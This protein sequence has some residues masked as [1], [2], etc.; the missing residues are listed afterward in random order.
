MSAFAT[1]IMSIAITAIVIVIAWI[2][3]WWLY[4]RATK[5]ISFVRTGFGGQKIIINGGSLV[6]PVLHDV[7]NVDMSTVRLEISRSEKDSIITR[8]RMRVDMTV[9]FYVRVKS[10]KEAIA[11]AAQTIGSRA[12]RSEPMREILEGRFID[13]LRTVTAEMSMEE[14]HEQRG[15]FISRVKQL[16]RNEIDQIGL[17]LE[18]ASLTVFDQTERTFFNPHN[19]F[20]AEGLTRLIDEIEARRM[21]RNEIEQ[22]SEVRI[23]QRNLEAET[24]KLAISREEEFIRL[25]Q[26]K[27]I[28]IRRAEQRTS[29]VSEEAVRRR[30]AEEAEIQSTRNIE[31]AKVQAEQ[32]LELEKLNTNQEVETVKHETGRLVEESMLES[33]LSIKLR[34]LDQEKNIALNKA[35]QNATVSKAEA[36]FKRLAEEATIEASQLVD[37]ARVKSKRDF[38]LEEISAETEMEQG[39]LSKNREVVVASIEKDIAIDQSRIDQEKRLQLSEQ[40]RNIEIAENSM[41]EVSAMTAA[42]KAKQTLVKAEEELATMREREREERVKLVDII[43]ATS[44]AEKAKIAAVISAEATHQESIELAEAAKIKTMSESARLRTMAEAEAEAEKVRAIGMEVRNEVE[45]KSLSALNE[46][47]NKLSSE[48][49]EMKVRLSVIENLK[50]II[51]ESVKPLE[52]IDGIKIVQ[53]DGLTSNGPKGD[54]DGNPNNLTDNVVNSALR[55]RAQAPIVDSLLSELGF[56]TS[57]KTPLTSVLTS[58]TNTKEAAVEDKQTKKE[59]DL[60]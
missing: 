43:K 1:T 7:V 42:E 27:D 3:F 52:N 2:L 49:I 54:I 37:I 11:L 44:V 26:E 18:S 9:E 40:E 41:K 45:A 57:A 58:S 19:A 23:Q 56:D 4:R 24:K 47:D 60:D 32:Q 14:L 34:R 6:I 53:V 59:G 51:R 15:E 50:D 38:A 12:G 5:E 21:K 35:E 29:I 8:D 13:A 46:A 20:D 33:E 16:V 17:E 28:A 36:E 55:Y 31:I 48:L 30:E 22:E 10:T 39:K 25:E